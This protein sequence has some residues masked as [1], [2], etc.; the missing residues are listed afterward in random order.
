MNI[1]KRLNEKGDKITFYYD[2]G[3][4]KGQ[5][6]STGVF[7]YTNPKTL[8]EKKHNKE[9]LAIIKV[10]QAES[11]IERQA[12]GTGYIPNHKFKENFLDYYEEY[13]KKNKRDGNR[14]LEGSFKNFKLFITKDTVH[15]ME[16]NE[17]LCA[18]F[19]RHLLDNFNG[20]TPSDYFSH[21]KRVL[22]AAT[23]DHYYKTS[24]AEKIAARRNPSTTLKDF[25]EAEEFL[26]LIYTPCPDEQVG[27]GY[28]F[29]CYT[30]LRWVDVEAMKW[31]DLNGNKLTTRIIQA[32]TG[33]PVVLTLHPVALAILK[34]NFAI[35]YKEG[36]DQPI[37]CLPSKRTVG[38]VMDKWVARTNIK[39][40]IRPS[41]ARLTFAIL[42]KDENVD[43]PT[44][45][46]LLGHTTTEQV[47]KIYKRHRP[48]NEE[49]TIALLPSKKELPFFF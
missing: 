1:I 9:A 47:Q 39:K 2:Y 3:R 20:E 46:A 37:F 29:G 21:F 8:L 35:T 27:L 49:A 33:Q 12:I 24:P 34:K 10:K 22:Q 32:K 45:A 19:R 23:A 7:I 16:I 15:P 5:R 28:T 26:E 30:G 14:H 40:K 36:K 44:I 13:V 48:K 43:D 17:N 38:I 41:S 18:S 11:I 4:G 6:P 25:L 31:S 42:L